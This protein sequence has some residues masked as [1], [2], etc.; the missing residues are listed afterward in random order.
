MVFKVFKF[1]EYW[2][3]INNLCQWKAIGIQLIPHRHTVNVKQVHS[4]RHTGIQL[5]SQLHTVSVT[6]AISLQLML[7]RLTINGTL[8]Y[9]QCHIC[10]CHFFIGIQLLSHR[11]TVDVKL[12][13]S[14]CFTSKQLTS[15]WHIVAFEFHASDAKNEMAKIKCSSTR[16]YAWLG[17]AQ[18]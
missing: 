12:T 16:A 8:V 7:H 3:H 6:Q 11:H 2:L 14:Y 15:H 4:K 18:F 17:T 5:M 9:S 1:I 13:Y 10:Y